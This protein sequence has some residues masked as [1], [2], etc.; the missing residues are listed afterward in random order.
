MKMLDCLLNFIFEGEFHCGIHHLED[1]V[2]RHQNTCILKS[3]ACNTRG[4]KGARVQTRRKF[5]GAKAVQGK[6][7]A[8]RARVRGCGIGDRES[9][10]R[11]STSRLATPH[12][13]SPRSIIGVGGGWVGGINFFH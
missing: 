3:D 11:L 12:G 4:L 6:T 13:R 7:K 10:E 1:L 8:S 9:V 2:S 5:D